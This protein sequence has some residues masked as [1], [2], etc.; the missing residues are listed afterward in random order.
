MTPEPVEYEPI[1]GEIHHHVLSVLVENKAGVLHRV[2]GL[3]SRRG[4]NIYSLAVAPTDP[5]HKFSRITIVVDAASAPLEQIVNQLDKLINVVE[6]DHVNERQVVERE[7][8]LATISVSAEEQTAAITLC[9]NVGAQVVDARAG[10]MT[11]MLADHPDSINAFQELL[12]VF[13]IDEL[14]RTGLVALPKLSAQ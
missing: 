12:G 10:E 2:A 6:I 5:S 11:V 8:F 1:S 3:F 7:L 14:H 4:F 9:S 13:R